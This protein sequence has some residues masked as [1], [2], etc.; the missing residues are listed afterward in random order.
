M[1]YATEDIIRTLKEARE[2]KGLSQRALSTRI[3]VPQSHISKIETGGA[4]IRISSLIEIARA[5]DLELKLV[6]RK[7]VP[8]VDTVVRS[9]APAPP[10]KSGEVQR[11]LRSLSTE[12]AFLKNL[13]PD[14]QEL[15]QLQKIFSQLRTL[16]VINTS[17]WQAIRKAMKPITDWGK[18]ISEATKLSNGHPKQL[19]EASK[20]PARRLKEISE[21]TKLSSERLKEF[22]NAASNVQ[23]LRNALLHN[24]SE[25]AASLPA[26][27]LADD[28]HA[29]GNDDG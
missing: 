16:P 15:T 2:A 10:P 9:T 25:R 3:G 1:T 12:I 11:Q 29:D 22:Q 13:Y 8:A 17:T 14:V 27:Q 18:E 24:L 4:D 23:Q 19:A 5:L 26:H 28:D 20:L 21:T 7:A 6:P